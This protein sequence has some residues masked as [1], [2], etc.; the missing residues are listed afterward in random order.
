MEH[1]HWKRPELSNLTFNQIPSGIISTNLTH[2]VYSHAQV[3]ATSTRTNKHHRLYWKR[4]K[5]RR[6]RSFG[7]TMNKL[8][9]TPLIFRHLTA[10]QSI[11]SS[12]KR[13]LCYSS[14]ILTE[15]LTS[16][17][18]AEFH[19]RRAILANITGPSF[20]NTN[21]PAH[22]ALR[23]YS[24]KHGKDSKGSSRAASNSDDDD[25]NNKKDKKDKLD[26]KDSEKTAADDEEQRNK[27]SPYKTVKRGPSNTAN[28]K[29]DKKPEKVAYPERTWVVDEDFE[30]S[31]SEDED[32]GHSDGGDDQSSLV[33]STVPPYFP[34]VPIIASAYPIFP[35]FMKVF[36]V[37]DPHMIQMLEHNFKNGRSYAGVFAHKNGDGTNHAVEVKS[38]DDVHRIGS[39]VH[40]TEMTKEDNKL[41][42][43]AT[44][45]RRIE[46]SEE[47][48]VNPN[49]FKDNTFPLNAFS[50]ENITKDPAWN[51]LMVDTENVEDKLPDVLSDKYK[52]ISMELVKT[53]RDI[54]MAN[55]LIRDNLYQLLGNNLRVNDSPGYLADISASITSSKP[56]EMQAIMEERDVSKRMELALELLMKEKTMLE[57]QKRIGKEVEDKIKA[58]HRDFLLR[59]QLKVLKKELGM[60]KEDNVALEEKYRKALEGKVVPEAVSIIIDEEIKKLGFLENS[61]Q[62]FT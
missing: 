57:L 18:S 3:V 20:Q 21:L 41:R 22:V 42:F 16:H 52:A 38:L 59:E 26:I 17:S 6:R 45:N 43:V 1:T 51:V 35:R 49:A 47:V 31:D 23:P 14:S 48:F 10:K 28:N 29:S 32:D 27:K 19:H 30:F 25:E 36:E 46:I 40:I 50:T 62:E 24:S 33:P 53:I 37:T 15:N 9:S 7:L 58:T 4:S 56:V 2:S 39:F 54:I 44:A 11:L 55:S 34:R 60:H 61:S 5:F 8:L 13:S 12:S